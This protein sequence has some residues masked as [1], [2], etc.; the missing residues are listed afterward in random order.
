MRDFYN[1]QGFWIEIRAQSTLVGARFF[2][3]TTGAPMGS[4][5]VLAWTP[6]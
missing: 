1:D 4:H 5:V 3:N 2:L 6:K